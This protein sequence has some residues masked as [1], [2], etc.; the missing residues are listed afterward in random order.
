MK[1]LRI[2]A[3]A[4]LPD[5]FS[6]SM[7]DALRYVADYR[8]TTPPQPSPVSA[9]HKAAHNKA[10]ADLEAITWPVFHEAVTQRGTQQLITFGVDTLDEGAWTRDRC[11]PEYFVPVQVAA[12][13]EPQARS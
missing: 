10:V 2:H 3:W 13:V 9:E 7:E 11:A 4:V 12:P 1:V 6:G 5:D 8:P